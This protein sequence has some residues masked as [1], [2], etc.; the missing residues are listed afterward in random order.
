[1][2]I[3]HQILYHWT[4]LQVWKEDLEEHGGTLASSYLT[5]TGSQYGTLEKKPRVGSL[6]L[7]ACRSPGFLTGVED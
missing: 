4:G 5:G 1:M 3:F 2:V 7:R 6:A